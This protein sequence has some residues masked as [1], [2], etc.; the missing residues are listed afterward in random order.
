MFRNVE[1]VCW[2]SLCAASDD[3]KIVVLYCLYCVVMSCCK[4][5]G[6]NRT[7]VFQTRADVLFICECESLCC[8]KSAPVSVWSVLSRCVHICLMCM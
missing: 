3:S 1:M 7:G 8:P 2:C 4:V 6:P 5:W